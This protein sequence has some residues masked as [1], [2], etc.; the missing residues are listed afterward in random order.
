MDLQPHLTGFSQGGL[1]LALQDNQSLSPPLLMDN[2]YNMLF[3][4]DFL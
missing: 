2:L 1:L 4:E 3:I